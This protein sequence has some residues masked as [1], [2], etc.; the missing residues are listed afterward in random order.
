MNNK[1]I[2]LHLWTLPDECA[3]I[4]IGKLRNLASSYILNGE[5]DMAET[6]LRCIRD[7]ENQLTSYRKEEQ[8][9]DID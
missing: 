6:L 1:T 9:N 8:E 7:A 3:D 5:D 2:S 4:L